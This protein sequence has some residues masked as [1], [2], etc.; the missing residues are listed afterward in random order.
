MKSIARA[1]LAL[2]LVLLVA[3]G[4]QPQSPSAPA[5]APAAPAAPAAAAA[6]PAP[7]TPVKVWFEG[8]YEDGLAQA[9]ASNKLVFVDFWTTWCGYCKKLD[10]VTFSQP[11]VQA[12]LSKMVSMSIDAESKAGAPIAQKFHV[13][14]YPAL[15]VLDGN[16]KEIGRIAGFLEPEPF[17][18][19]LEAIRARAAR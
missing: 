2:P 6:A 5:Q 13:T 11:A 16:G 14:G 19:R 8:S 15:L 4:P 7:P 18:K 12:E 1:V 3:C 17:L 10:K 9:R